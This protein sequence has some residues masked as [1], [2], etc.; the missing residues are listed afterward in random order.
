MTLTIKKTKHTQDHYADKH[1]AI[2]R[3]YAQFQEVMFMYYILFNPDVFMES[4]NIVRRETV[5]TTYNS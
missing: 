5:Q 4:E 2:I 1:Q 3:E